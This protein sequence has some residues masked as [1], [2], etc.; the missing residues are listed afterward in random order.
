MMTP[1]IQA[2]TTTINQSMMTRTPLLQDD[3]LS[4]NQAKSSTTLIHA[5]SEMWNHQ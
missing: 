1:L 3:A 4:F 5:H 2:D